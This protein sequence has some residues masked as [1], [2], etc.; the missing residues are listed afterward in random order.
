MANNWGK[1]EFNDFIELQKKLDSF[2]KTEN[3][4]EDVAKEL[5]ARLLGKVIPRT[6]VDTGQL[7]KG[8]T[9]ETHEDAL[10]SNN[11]D[12]KTYVDSL[13]I[14]KTKSYVEVEIRNPVKHAKF[15]EL[16]YRT[17]DLQGWVKGR[18]FLRIS[19]NDINSE[20]DSI[21]EKIV[22]SKLKEVF[23]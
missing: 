19:L 16:G 10:N 11:M 12:V 21:V 8:W 23:L 20:K 3:L 13:D 1:S 18:H 17:R 6:P 4:L 2:I 15:Q 7:R 5:S 22:L 9:S 14:I